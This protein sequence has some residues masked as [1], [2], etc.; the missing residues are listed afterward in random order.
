M[1]G[2]EEKHLED[3]SVSKL[4][5]F[6]LFSFNIYFSSFIKQTHLISFTDSLKHSL[7]FILFSNDYEIEYLL[8]NLC[9]MIIWCLHKQL[10]YMGRESV[11]FSDLASFRGET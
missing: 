1:G 8:L 4:V 5:S 9:L 11:I 10:C 6:R 3:C 7:N 2:G